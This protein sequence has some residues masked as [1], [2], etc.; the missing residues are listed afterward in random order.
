MEVTIQH[1]E[2]AVT[3][4]E[5]VITKLDRNFEHPQFTEIHGVRY[6]RHNRKDEL[7][8]S[9]LK[10]VGSISL[11]NASL[12]LLRQG[13]VKEIGILCRCIGDNNDD[14]TLMSAPLGNDG[15]PSMEQERLVKEFFQE[16]FD[17]ADPLLSMQK[18][19]R[20]PRKKI[21]SE[22]T[23]LPNFS[24][25]P[26]DGKNMFRCLHQTFSGYVHSAYVHIMEFY[27]GETETSAC[28]HM[29]GLLGTPRIPI[30]TETLSNYV[31]R[32]MIAVEIVAKRCCDIDAQR[33]IEKYRSDFE[34]VTGVGVS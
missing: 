11:L 18:R 8:M 28:Y 15:K 13:F 27:G 7:L 31:Y 9:Y 26:S 4:M 23:K 33:H 21:H 19:D 5:E 22:I 12:A 6:L 3:N 14:V 1:L 20:V 34:K 24:L 16:E 10:C 29:H 2:E 17:N 30:W 32:T 25:N